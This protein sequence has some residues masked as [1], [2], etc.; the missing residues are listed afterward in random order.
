MFCGTLEDKNIENS[1]EDGGLT[2]DI[3]KRKFKDSI[4]TTCYFDLQFCGYYL[5]EVKN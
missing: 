1:A 4:K 5:V 2:C 3:I